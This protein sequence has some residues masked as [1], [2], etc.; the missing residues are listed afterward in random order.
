MSACKS[1]VCWRCGEHIE[2]GQTVG[3]VGRFSF[4]AGEPAVVDH[5]GEFLY[6]HGGHVLRFMTTEGLPS[7]YREYQR[8]ED[9]PPAPVEGEPHDDPTEDERFIAAALEATPSILDVIQVLLGALRAHS[10]L[11][12]IYESYAGIGPGVH[13]VKGRVVFDTA[14]DG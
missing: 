4:Y 12:V 8:A 5:L 13:T 2:V 11:P 9:R 14:V 10:N 6:L 7:W 1:V 3:D